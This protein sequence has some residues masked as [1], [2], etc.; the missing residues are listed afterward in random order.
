MERWTAKSVHAPGS[1]P[2]NLQKKWNE[3][4]Y[5]HKT[6]VDTLIGLIHICIEPVCN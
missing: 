6:V 5:K 3:F 4:L 2:G 1:S